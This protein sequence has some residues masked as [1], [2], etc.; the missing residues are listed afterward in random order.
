[1][2][3]AD[4]GKKDEKGMKASEEVVNPVMSDPKSSSSNWE[5]SGEKRS[6][7]IIQEIAQIEAPGESAE[8]VAVEM[9][10]NKVC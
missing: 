9:G 6:S 1:M 5:K 7:V 4:A 3:V 10:V 8:H 2:V